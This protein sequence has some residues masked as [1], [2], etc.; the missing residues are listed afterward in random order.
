[1]VYSSAS[2]IDT[3]LKPT[4]VAGSKGS[5]TRITSTHAAWRRRMAAEDTCA[6][7]AAVVTMVSETMEIIY[8]WSVFSTQVLYYRLFTDL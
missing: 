6:V 5:A 1:L 7:A 3:L 4:C 2:H 8:S